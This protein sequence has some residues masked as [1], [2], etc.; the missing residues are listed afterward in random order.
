MVKEFLITVNQIVPALLTFSPSSVSQVQFLHHHP[1]VCSHTIK[2]FSLDAKIA[3]E[4][5]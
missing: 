1:T 3:R 2:G 5:K 4:Q